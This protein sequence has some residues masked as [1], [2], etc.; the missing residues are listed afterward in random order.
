MV[1]IGG[2]GGGYERVAAAAAALQAVTQHNQRP[3]GAGVSPEVHLGVVGVRRAGQAVHGGEQRKPVVRLDVAQP[4]AEHLQQ[5]VQNAQRLRLEHGRQQSAR[6]VPHSRF[7]YTGRAADG[8]TSQLHSRDGDGRHRATV[9][10]SQYTM[11]GEGA[12]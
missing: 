5:R 1:V 9:L 11:A 12:R 3:V 2:G 7:G 4:A 10:G 8:D 6:E